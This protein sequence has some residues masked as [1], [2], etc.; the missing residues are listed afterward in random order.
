MIRRR[1]FIAGVGSAAAWPV[2]ARAQQRTMPIIGYIAPFD[3]SSAPGRSLIAFRKGLSE[4]GYVEGQNV[5]IEYRGTGGRNDPLTASPVAKEFVDRRVSVIVAATVPMAIG[6]K[7][8]TPTIPIVVRAGTD[9][10]AAGLV[11]SLSRPGANVTGISTFS[12]DL[13]PKR[14]GL[15][16][17]FLPKGATVAVLVSRTNVVAA[18]EA[19]EVEAAAGNFRSPDIVDF[20][21]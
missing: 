14:L 13:G 8:L 2:G 10:V 7:K 19:K 21:D 12:Q 4:T 11:T 16:R 5:S 20:R 1:Q 9:P 15:L 17:E 3:D 6:I 18:A